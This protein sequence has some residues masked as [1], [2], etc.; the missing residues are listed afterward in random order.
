MPLSFCAGISQQAK[1]T[2]SIQTYPEEWNEVLL[3][4]VPCL[5]IRVLR[6]NLLERSHLLTSDRLGTAGHLEDV[7]ETLDDNT[8]EQVGEDVLGEDVRPRGAQVSMDECDL[9]YSVGSKR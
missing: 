1:R 8:S 4:Q 6:P 5:R 7:V 2:L 3:L 9:P